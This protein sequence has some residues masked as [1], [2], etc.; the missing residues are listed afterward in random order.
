MGSWSFQIRYWRWAAQSL[1]SNQTLFCATSCAIGYNF[2]VQIGV[3]GGGTSANVYAKLAGMLAATA[4]CSISA[5]V[6][7]RR[8]A[9]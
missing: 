3:T 9:I 6:K 4:N 2:W 5:S 1:R 7:V 8:E